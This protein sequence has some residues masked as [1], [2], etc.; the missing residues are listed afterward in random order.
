M[1][2]I[3]EFVE[4]KKI[5]EMQFFF[6]R[7][8]HSQQTGK[9]KRRYTLPIHKAEDWFFFEIVCFAYAYI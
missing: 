8:T 9:W 7:R 1:A 3:G 4:K 6:Q 2:L 5:I